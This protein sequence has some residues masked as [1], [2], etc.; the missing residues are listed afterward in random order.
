MSRVNWSWSPNFGPSN[1]ILYGP[2]TF[3]VYIKS[4]DPEAKNWSSSQKFGSILMPIV[5]TLRSLRKNHRNKLN[6]LHVKDEIKP[7][8]C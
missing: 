5:A 3:Y 4:N 6:L 2:Y 7:F 1:T 8:A